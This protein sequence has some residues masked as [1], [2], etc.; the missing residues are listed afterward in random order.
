MPRNRK[1]RI[2]AIHRRVIPALRLR[3]LLKAATPFEIASTP[4]RAVVPLENAW[5]IKKRPMGSSTFG[6]SRGAGAWTQPRAPLLAPPSPKDP[7]ARA[8][9]REQYEGKAEDAP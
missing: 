7:G 9:N 4:V 1:A 3:G 5:R 6:A 8:T 2:P